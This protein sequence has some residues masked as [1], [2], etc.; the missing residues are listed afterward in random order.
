MNKIINCVIVGYGYVAQHFHCPLIYSTS[1]LNLFGIVSSRQLIPSIIPQQF[2]DKIL[3]FSSIE[4]ALLNENVDLIIIT[5][6]NSTHFQLGLQCLQSN[7]HVII[8]KPMCLTV[9]ECEQLIN[10]AQNRNLL[11]T[12]FHNRR[13]DGDFLTIKKIINDGTI[14]QPRWVEASYLRSAPSSKAWKK[15]SIEE[16]GGTFMDLGVH[17][18]D[19]IL[20]LFPTTPIIRIFCRMQFD[21][22]GGKESGDSET[23]VCLEFADGRSAI[24]NTSSQA[25]IH[26]PRYYIHGTQGSLMKF[27]NDEQETQLLKAQGRWWETGTTGKSLAIEFMKSAID[28]PENYTTIFQRTK[29]DQKLQIETLSGNWSYFYENIADILL[30]F[31]QDSKIQINSKTAIKLIEMHRLFKVIDAILKSAE[32][33]QV[34]NFEDIIT[35]I[36]N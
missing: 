6:P 21:H 20:Q 11:L 9:S 35:T 8:D 24:C 30:Q 29:L 14:G 13:W 36:N 32:Q 12:V 18:L 33:R 25:A 34:I 19:Q 23:S 3:I 15:V 28:K 16:G 22:Q 27:G 17:I 4:Q 1:N 31:K 10:E 7:K 5:T 26:K 2:S